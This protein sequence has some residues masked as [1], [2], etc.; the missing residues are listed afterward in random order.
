MLSA[1]TAAGQFP[2]ESV[3]MMRQIVEYTEGSMRLRE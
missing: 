3:S 1:E 2:V